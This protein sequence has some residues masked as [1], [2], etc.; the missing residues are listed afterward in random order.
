MLSCLQSSMGG[1]IRCMIYFILM[2]TLSFFVFEACWDAPF[3][4]GVEAILGNQGKFLKLRKIDS[5]QGIHHLESEI[6]FGTLDQVE[7]SNIDD[8]LRGDSADEQGFRSILHPLE[9]PTPT[10]IL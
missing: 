7:G 10:H 6:G 9:A 3:S 5:R 4:C 8:L 1:A 2:L